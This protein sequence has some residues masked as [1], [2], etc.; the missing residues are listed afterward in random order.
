MDP[1][2][3][4]P[5]VG[6]RPGRN[7]PLRGHHGTLVTLSSRPPQRVAF[8]AMEMPSGV[9]SPCGPLLP[10]C[11]RLPLVS[12]VVF[13]SMLSVLEPALGFGLEMWWWC[14]LINREEQAFLLVQL[15]NKNTPAFPTVSRVPEEKGGAA[16]S[17]RSPGS[18][19]NAVA[20]G[21]AIC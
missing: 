13:L 5:A 14:S 2:V 10:C 1:G 12:R 7:G 20:E 15:S 9:S 8:A 6:Q 17:R 11:K 21:L 3:E 16:E 18:T 19:A 4:R